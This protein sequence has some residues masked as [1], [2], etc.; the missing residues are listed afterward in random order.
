MLNP[1]IIEQIRKRE[2]EQA[3]RQ[4]QEL[5]LEL[6]KPPMYQIP[7]DDEPEVERGVYI[8]DLM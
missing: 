5:T 7:E 6:P 3:K 4:Q 8:I 2:L 1:V